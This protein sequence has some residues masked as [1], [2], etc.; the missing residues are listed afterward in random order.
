MRQSSLFIALCIVLLLQAPAVAQKTRLS[1]GVELYNAGQYAQAINE[2]AAAQNDP[3]QMSKA[4]Y[5]RAL[6]ELKL[7][8]TKEAADTLRALV[9]LAPT[10][11]EAVAAKDYLQKLQQGNRPTQA[12]PKH[13]KIP[14]RL[15]ADG[16]MHV[17]AKAN[18]QEVDLV[19][20]TGA[21]N[22]SLPLQYA[23]SIPPG[24]VKIN[25]ETPH[26]TKEAWAAPI[27]IE[28]G[29]LK[30]KA[31]TTLMG[32]VAVLGQSFFG[33]YKVEFNKEHRNIYLDYV[34]TTAGAP[35]TRRNFSKFQ[36]PFEKEAGILLVDIMLDGRPTKAYFDTGC[37]AEGVAMSTA[38]AQGR[39]YMDLTI[40]PISR[41]RV[42]ITI[43]NGMSRPLVGPA[44]FGD[45]GYK[46]DPARQVIDFDYVRE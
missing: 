6:S 10:S 42:P 2:L 25:V 20:D 41:K 22:C 30:R 5:Y 37:A 17:T 18:G 26:G 4:L 28:V 46:I 35:P 13:V 24:A 34:A 32:D 31:M 40:G 29:G 9:R 7:S 38:A 33:D 16:W 1:K 15:G 39:R 21:T 36:V 8:K 3:A 45:R 23:S 11:S 44:I 27:E 43:A 14:Y 19:W 12:L